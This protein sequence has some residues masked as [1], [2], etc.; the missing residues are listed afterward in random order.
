MAFGVGQHFE[1]PGVRSD[2]RSR[3]RFPSGLYA[4]ARLDRVLVWTEPA[5][6]K[7]IG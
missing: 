1:V 6:Q 7:V 2:E 5:R 3:N 4:A